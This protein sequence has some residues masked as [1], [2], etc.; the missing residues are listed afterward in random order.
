MDSRTAIL[1][2]RLRYLVKAESQ[3]FAEEVVTA[4]FQRED[5]GTIRWLTPLQ[6]AALRLLRD[7]EVAANMPSIERKEHVEWALGM[8][9]EGWAESIVAERVTELEASHAR[10]RRAVK[11]SKERVTPHHP[12]DIIGCY[13]LV[14][15]GGVE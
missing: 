12:P 14:P 2:L 7:A 11:G 13:V 5:G 6:G 10:L 4:A 15:A 9:K 3:Q 1:V 8:L